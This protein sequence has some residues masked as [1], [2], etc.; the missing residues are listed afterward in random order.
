MNRAPSPNLPGLLAVALL[1]SLPCSAAPPTAQDQTTPSP[2][3]TIWGAEGYIEYVVGNA[4][5]VVSSGHGG[6]LTPSSIPDRTWGVTGRDLWTQETARA[7]TEAIIARTGRRPHL[8]IS[9]LARIK[10]DPNRAEEE[11]AQGDPTAQKAW[12][13]FHAF[14]DQAR[15]QITSQHGLGMYVDIHGHAHSEGW[16]E[17]GYLLTNSQLALSNAALS[18]SKLISASSYR[19]LSAR[20][21]V[22]FPAALRGRSSLGGLLQSA[23]YKSVPSPAHPDAGG[24]NY[25]RGGYNTNRHGSR[26]DGTVDGVQIELPIS[27][28]DKASTRSVFADALASA[29]DS[30]FR[31]FHGLDLSHG[32]IVGV[33]ASSGTLPESNGKASFEV[34]RSGD[35]S[36]PV[37]VTY[38][39]RGSATP[40]EDYAA[41]QGSV[42]LASGSARAA[43][44][45]RSLDDTLAEG[46]ETVEIV[47]QG[48]VEI[49]ADNR[50]GIVILDD[51]DDP[52]MLAY[53]PLDETSGSTARDATGN[54][55]DGALAPLGASGPRHV[56]GKRGRCLH[57]DG[58]DDRMSIQD[59]SYSP[60]AD[61]TVAF[62]FKAR[63]SGSS[64]YR[65][66]F[67]HGPAGAPSSLNTY[68]LESSGTLRTSLAFKN[69]LSGR[70]VLDVTDDARDGHWHHYAVS[71][72]ARGLTR[73]YLD[74]RE[75]AVSFLAGDRTDPGGALLL[76][77]RSDLDPDRFYGGALDELRI[78]DR[79]LTAAE[80]RASLMAP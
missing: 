53:L 80:V 66:M 61:H 57:F 78:W 41:L 6:Y 75:V 45:L 8:I 79:A 71:A 67:S 31:R 20:P 37:T 10:L 64:G 33:R 52:H 44:P 28:R 47:L 24:G 69:D 15:N 76:G 13:E 77:G 30:F 49:G 9:H 51:E 29:L 38:T 63:P 2:G 74:G 21:G 11:A 22:S 73:I 18:D 54:G 14:I 62:W 59:F 4:P 43:V 50:A 34:F 7:V 55:N 48:G 40:G 60:D 35:L 27:A 36:Q 17:F 12:A 46:M 65:Y 56:L 58:R 68:F 32:P 16:I 25:F 23:G 19:A 5:L 26:I 39:V 42:S 1:A 3:T 72:S 70:S